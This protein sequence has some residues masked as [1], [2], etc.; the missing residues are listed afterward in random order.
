MA[1]VNANNLPLRTASLGDSLLVNDEAGTGRMDIDVLGLYVYPQ[2]DRDKV[3]SVETGATADQTGAEIR[4]LLDAEANTNILTDTLLTKLTGIADNANLFVL[5]PATRSVL[6]GVIVGQGL[7]LTNAGVLSVNIDPVETHVYTNQTGTD[8]SPIV[9]DTYF[10]NDSTTQW[11]QGDFLIFSASGNTYIY[12]GTN[13]ATSP[14]L[15]NDFHQ[16]NVAAD[17]TPAVTEDS[18][19]VDV[20]KTVE[21]DGHLYVD[22]GSSGFT[23]IYLGSADSQSIFRLRGGNSFTANTHG[24]LAANTSGSEGGVDITGYGPSGGSGINNISVRGSHTYFDH[25][26]RIGANNAANEFDYYEEGIWTPTFNIVGGTVALEPDYDGGT[27]NAATFTRKGREYTCTLKQHIGAVTNPINVSLQ[28][29]GFPGPLHESFYEAVFT[30]NVRDSSFTRT[31]V[32]LP[33][34]SSGTYFTLD[35]SFIGSGDILLSVTFT[36]FITP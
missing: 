14:N 18:N 6:G 36:Y 15:A 5:Q 26:I 34:N 29:G 1:Q 35:D 12:T 32:P 17:P 19:S 21:I 7:D 23:S 4:T 8:G 13:N 25:P 11:N 2:A 9:T 24:I 10:A 22:R 28:I 30:G 31:V 27:S 3:T 16:V 20:S 33:L